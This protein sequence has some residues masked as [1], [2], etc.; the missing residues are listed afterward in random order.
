MGCSVMRLNAAF[1]DREWPKVESFLSNGLMASEGEITVD[2]LR[3]LCAK[4]LAE[5]YVALKDDK[6]IG[7]AAVEAIIYPNFRAA[8]VISAGGRGIYNK[9]FW[10]L[11][12][13]WLRDQ[14]YSKVQGYC[15]AP[16]AR[17][18]RRIEGFRTAY[19]LVRADL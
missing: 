2:Q 7:A 4:G 13:G 5:I 11:F 19:E 17:L 9:D 12:M 10:P 8:N 1:L 14:G 15:P 6:V 3:L 16:V 18:L